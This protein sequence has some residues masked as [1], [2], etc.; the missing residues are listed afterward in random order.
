MERV[1][2]NDQLRINRLRKAEEDESAFRAQEE[3]R[4]QEDATKRTVE[5]KKKVEQDRNKKELEYVLHLVFMP[6]RS[7]LANHV[8]VEHSD[9][10]E[11]NRQ[12]KL[13]AVQAREWDS[14]KT[15][16]DYNP[17]KQSSRFSRGAHGGVTGPPTP[18]R[19]PPTPPRGAPTGPRR[20]ATG[21]RRPSSKVS[22]ASQEWP[23]LPPPTND[24][25]PVKNEPVVEDDPAANNTP[26]TSDQPTAEDELTDKA[27]PQ[28]EKNAPGQA[29]RAPEQAEKAIEKQ[30]P[31]TGNHANDAITPLSPAVGGGSWAEQVEA[32]T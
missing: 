6:H 27:Q 1:K 11:K 29:E 30:K 4:K 22:S 19:G 15:E 26:S 24:K 5:R 16:E 23:G 21:P 25:P 7:T 10:R 12:R 2:L 18:A 3:A 17:R 14:T 31:K 13:S 32:S 8:I 28:A 9:E 20:G